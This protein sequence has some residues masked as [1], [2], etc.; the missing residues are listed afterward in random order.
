[1]KNLKNLLK[2]PLNNVPKWV[3]IAI[4]AISLIGFAD[5]AF[6]TLEHYKGEIPP[7]LVGGCEQVLTSEYSTILGIPVAL[8]GSLY[9]LFIAVLVFMAIESKS[10]RILKLAMIATAIG[11]LMSLWFLYLQAFVI[12]SYCQYC[13]ISTVTSTAIFVISY[14][15]LW[16]Y[17]YPTPE[18]SMQVEG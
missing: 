10:N 1:M 5:A 4:L 6:L 16:R 18:S 12:N 17:R 8:Y 13:L 3:P 11:F 14:W 15:S 7:C 2:S 9:Y